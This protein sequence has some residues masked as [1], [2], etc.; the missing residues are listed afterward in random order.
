M[1]GPQSNFYSATRSAV[2][3]IVRPLS[4][5]PY[6]HARPSNVTESFFS[7]TSVIFRYILLQNPRGHFPVQCRRR[8]FRLGER[9]RM[10]A[11]CNSSDS[12][13]RH[14][15]ARCLRQAL[16]HV[17]PVQT[18]PANR[19]HC[20]RCKRSHNGRR[21]SCGL[22]RRINPPHDAIGTPPVHL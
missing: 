16:C 10:W 7:N 1:E 15:H 11:L 2:S 6:R 14:G 13:D 3:R 8:L 4:L 20:V 17:H 21:L 12:M 19:V 18:P 5:P 22:S 9:S